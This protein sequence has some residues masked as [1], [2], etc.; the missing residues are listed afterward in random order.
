MKKNSIFGGWASFAVLMVFIGIALVTTAH[1]G[2][3]HAVALD[4]SLTF[5]G[6]SALGFVGAMAD[7]LINIQ[8]VGP[9]RVAILTVPCNNTYDKFH[10]ELGGGLMA[11]DITLIEGK[12]NGK[13]FFQDTGQRAVL[14]QAYKKIYTQAS[15]VTLDFTEPK[16][17]GGALPQFMASI[18]GNLLASLTFEVTIGGAANALS[19]LNASS[20]FRGPTQNPYIRKQ[21]ISNI[22]LP[23]VGDNDVFL[24]AGKAG[25]LVKRIWL[26]GTDKLT[27]YQLRV[28][29][30]IKRQQNKAQWLNEQNENDLVPTATCDVID[31]I[32]D[33]N[34]AQGLLNTAGDGKTVPDVQLRATVSAADALA[35]YIEYIDPIGRL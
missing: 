11:A 24:P 10:L 7:N 16:A 15:R 22:N 13:V 3:V 23:I 8:N 29:S 4:H 26:H 12:A 2:A 20:E 30:I 1:A 32:A 5:G 18:P 19:T 9:G 6:L 33:G 31:F 35:V 14:R 34:I 28:D 27:A 25:G 17:R 21:L